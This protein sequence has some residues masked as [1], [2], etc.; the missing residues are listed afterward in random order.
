MSYVGNKKFFRYGTLFAYNVTLKKRYKSRLNSYLKNVSATRKIILKLKK[1]Y[2]K[3][4]SMQIRNAP[5]YGHEAI[6]SFILC[7]F[8]LLVLNPIFGIKKK[9]DFSDK[10]ITKALKFMEKKY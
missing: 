7:R 8:D 6:F 4:C 9:N 3:I 5:H 1:K 2:K 10:F